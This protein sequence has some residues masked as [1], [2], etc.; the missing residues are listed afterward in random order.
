LEKYLSKKV[1]FNL[2]LR[3]GAVSGFGGLVVSLLASSTEVREFEPGRKRKIPQH[4]FIQK[5]S[6]FV[7]PMSQLC[8]MLK[9]P[10]IYVE[11]GLSGKILHAISRP[12]FFPSITQV[13]QALWR[14]APLKMNGGS[15]KRG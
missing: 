7:C 14:G 13:S 9:N 10:V 2:T 11:V 4:A 8:G 6:K 3:E 15:K 5:G 1:K 12:Y